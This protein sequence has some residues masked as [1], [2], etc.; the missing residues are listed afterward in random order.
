MS[1][2]LTSGRYRL[3]IVRLRTKIPHKSRPL[4]L[5]LLISVVKL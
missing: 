4:P 2:V 1:M 3:P 5:S